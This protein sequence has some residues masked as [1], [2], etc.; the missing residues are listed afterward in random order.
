MRNGLAQ[1]SKSGKVL[2]SD[3]AFKKP[4]EWRNTVGKGRMTRA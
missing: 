4:N 2:K 1:V 3:G